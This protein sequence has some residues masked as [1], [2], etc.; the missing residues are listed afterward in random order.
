[1]TAAAIRKSPY[2]SR[3]PQETIAAVD[4]LRGEFGITRLA[5]IT[6][7]DRVGLPVFQSIRPNAPSVSVS[8]GKGLDADAARASALMEACE[9]A[10]A[11]AFDL[12][13]LI[14]STAQLPP[15]ESPH[16][17]NTWPRMRRRLTRGTKLRWVKARELVTGAPAWVPRELVRIDG[18]DRDCTDAAYFVRT[19]NGL[20]SGN[21]RAEAVLSALC[22]VIERDALV[23]WQ[24]AGLPR[25]AG[26]RLVLGT[27]H[28]ARC[29]ALVR[30][31]A[32][33]QIGLAVW[34]TTGD[35]GVPCFVARIV[36]LPG[37][38]HAI[39][40]SFWGAGA[41][42]DRAIAFARAVTEAAQSRLTLIAGARDDLARADYDDEPDALATALDRWE[43]TRAV[44]RFGDIASLNAATVSSAVAEVVARLRR[45][46]LDRIFIVDLSLPGRGIAVVRAIVPGLET[47][48][49]HGRM[50]EGARLRRARAA[51]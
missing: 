20:A 46:G 49:R 35:T 25:R 13:T 51:A 48:D 10:H 28:D 36:D 4:R 9:I 15:D 45:A 8:L 34:D 30:R 29:Q 43:E 21:V 50:L 41:H 44:R 42:P 19:S 37:V 5:D 2:R 47:I 7:L 18:L 16:T 12:P 1:M 6:G 24:A 27:V 22:E 23:L 26:T 17:L 11:E 39:A 32:A 31:F 40:G 33:R 38:P 3:T 14:A